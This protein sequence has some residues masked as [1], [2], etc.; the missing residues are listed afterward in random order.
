[1]S[2]E[3]TRAPLIAHLRELKRRLIIAGL[4]YL[5][6]AILSYLFAEEIYR[7]LVHP[8]AEAYGP[9]KGRLIYT[10]LTEAFITY[11]KLACF[12][13][14]V[15]A[16]P[17]L[18]WQV[19][20]FIAPGLYHKEKRV[21]LPY[22]VVSPTLFILGAALAYYFVFPLA[23]KFFLSFEAPPVEGSLPIQMEARVSDY[24]SLVTQFILGFGLAFQLPVLLTL[25]ARAG[26]IE[27]AMLKGKRRYAI[28][29]IF[30]ASAVLTPPDIMSQICLALPL[31]LLY[32]LSILAC[33]HI[34]R[35]RYTHA[36][37]PIHPTEP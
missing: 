8:L 3:T 31:I 14:V 11:I 4:A 22:L 20:A 25:L 37:H 28:V 6:A 33:G 36:R 12:G 29:L 32:E 26:L 34:E 10:S 15:V 21:V 13:G 24:L 23:W 16:F 5:G 18:A 27:T 30:F 7:F 9:E 2:F 35:Q 1:M 17:V 19:Y